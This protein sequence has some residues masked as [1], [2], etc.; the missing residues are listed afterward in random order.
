MDARTTDESMSTSYSV[1]L[2]FSPGDDRPGLLE[3]AIREEVA[4]LGVHRSVTLAFSNGPPLLESPSVAV[5]FGGFGQASEPTLVRAVGEAQ[6]LLRTVIPLVDDLTHF[7]SAGAGSLG[8]CRGH[9]VATRNIPGG[10]GS[11]SA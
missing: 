9:G 6:G 4:R 7:H 10:C 5:F 1:E 8:G 2:I 3:S 11:T